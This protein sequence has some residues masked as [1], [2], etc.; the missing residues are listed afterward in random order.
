MTNIFLLTLSLL[1]GADGATQ[2]RLDDVV[3][4]LRNPDYR[5]RLEALRTLR[6]AKHVDAIAAIAPL[7]NDA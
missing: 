2:Q 3:R 7:I 6:E 4:N 5:A 1:L